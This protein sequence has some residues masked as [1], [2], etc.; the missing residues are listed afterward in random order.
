MIPDTDRD[1]LIWIPNCLLV[2][3]PNQ[4]LRLWVPDRDRGLILPEA[5]RDLIPDPHQDRI[6]PGRGH[7]H[8]PD[9]SLILLGRDHDHMIQDPDPDLVDQVLLQQV[10][11]RLH[12]NPLP[13]LRWGLEA[14]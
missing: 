1:L 9:R 4:D 13:K 8:T 5:N 11:D 10:M 14:R 3:H 6:L 12:Q 2:V 7:A